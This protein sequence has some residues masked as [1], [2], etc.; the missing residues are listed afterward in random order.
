MV[1]ER[2]GLKNGVVTL[3]GFDLD[4]SIGESNYFRFDGLVESIDEHTEKLCQEFRLQHKFK[5]GSSL[6]GR[7]LTLKYKGLVGSIIFYKD[8]GENH[9]IFTLGHESTDALIGY[10]MKKTLVDLFRGCGIFMDSNI[11]DIPKQDFC[12]AGGLLALKLKGQ[13]TEY[14][15]HHLNRINP[16]FVELMR[17]SG[18][19]N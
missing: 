14:A 18:Q 11:D 8:M 15:Q 5:E 16:L 13:S 17:Q 19:I 12:D 9:N 4:M 7:T 10:G 3:P 2:Y 6:Y 1:F